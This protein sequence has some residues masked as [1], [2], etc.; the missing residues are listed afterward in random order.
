MAIVA[1]IRKLSR[2]ELLYACVAKL[3]V[4]LHK[5]NR[6]ALP[7]ALKHYC[8][9]ND[10]NRTFY[11]NDGSGTDNRLKSILEDADK[12]LSVCG[13]DYDDVTEYQLLVRCLS[14]Q[15]V[16]EETIRRLCTKE[17]GVPFRHTPE[18]F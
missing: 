18:S 13:S 4:Y 8:D 3:A 1:N 11:Y 14:E 9:P 7:E 17:D 15:T 5:N 12:L 10:Y 16:V 6:K 2:A